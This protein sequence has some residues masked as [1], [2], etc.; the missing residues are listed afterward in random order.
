MNNIRVENKAT[1]SDGGASS[2]SGIAPCGCPR[3]SLPPPIPLTMPFSESEEGK[4]KEW[5]LAKNADSAFNC[6]SHQPLKKM[7]G[8]PLHFD[9]DP[10]V[11]P[12]AGHVQVLSHYTGTSKSNKGWRLIAGWVF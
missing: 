1:T 12:V 7:T 8:P 9:L 10:T 2:D 11:K 3:R 5:I 6:C 4:L